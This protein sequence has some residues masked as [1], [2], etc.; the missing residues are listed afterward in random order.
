MLDILPPSETLLQLPAGGDENARLQGEVAGMQAAEAEVSKTLHSN[1]ASTQV[2]NSKQQQAK[3]ETRTA[4]KHTTAQMLVDASSNARKIED[5]APTVL[6]EMATISKIHVNGKQGHAAG[7]QLLAPQSLDPRVILEAE[8]AM[9]KQISNLRMH[10]SGVFADQIERVSDGVVQL[11]VVQEEY[12]WE[13]PTKQPVKET[14]YGSGW[15]IDNEEFGV[16][17]KDDILIVTNA[18]VAKQG[19]SISALFPFIGLE[20]MKVIALGVC[21]ERD[22]ALLKVADPKYFLEIYK[23]KTG[24]DKIFKNKLGDSDK[25]KK[26][27]KVLAAG[28]P[29]GMHGVKTSKGIV[30]GYEPMEKDLYLSITAPINEGNSGGPLFNLDGHV[31]GINSAKLTDQSRIAFAIPSQQLANI[32][33][34]LYTTRQFFVPDLG[35]EWSQSS[36]DLNEYFTGIPAQGGVFIQS[37]S[38]G[39]LFD[40]AGAQ[41]GDILLAIDDRKLESDGT[42]HMEE[43]D[44]DVNIHGM[45]TRKLIGSDL[46]LDVYRGGG[47]SSNGT[48]TKLTTKY[49]QTEIPAVKHYAEEIEDVP[50]YETIAGLTLMELSVN[51]AE[52]FVDSNPE[53][54]VEFCDAE[55]RHT[56]SRLI[57]ADVEPASVA[58]SAGTVK[59]GQL[60]TSVNGQPVNDFKSLC[61][62]LISKDKYWTMTT[63]KS[64]TVLDAKEVHAAVY[65]WQ[66]SAPKK[67]ACA[68][69]VAAASKGRVDE[70]HGGQAADVTLESEEQT[71]TR[72]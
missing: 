69:L 65:A 37:V 70:P 46:L 49:D 38:S 14:V 72:S 52:N 45:L 12:M 30:S 47:D 13:Y 34:A 61:G 26:G 54:L 18:H 58:G 10:K 32:M 5:E 56:E 7:R 11:R 63:A 25:L 44:N 55:R 50:L 33:D 68:Q 40:K 28:F 22:I 19:F 59:T 66:K 2:P 23:L 4:Q 71:A 62:T 41:V 8:N 48:L 43:V 17:T 57:I 60:V 35:F 42:I 64:M 31:V 27:S 67:S 24:N 6:D 9:L 51:I 53:E 21:V 3:Q 39:G 29:L 15:I 16:D 1:I 20:P 36:P